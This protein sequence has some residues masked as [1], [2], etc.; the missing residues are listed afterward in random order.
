[1]KD[2]TP[3]LKEAFEKLLN[4]ASY[5]GSFNEASHWDRFDLESALQAMHAAYTLGIEKDKWV[6]IS[7]YPTEG[8]PKVLRWHHVWKC[9]VTVSHRRENTSNGCEW[10]DGTL[11]VVWPEASFTPFFKYPSPPQS[12]TAHK[13]V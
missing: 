7:E 8:S 6:P 10:I 2:L 1:M 3:E 9:Y 12:T 5:R 11:T 13:G 4:K